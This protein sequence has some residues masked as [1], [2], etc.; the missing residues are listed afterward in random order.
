MSKG[1]TRG[2]DLRIHSRNIEIDEPTGEYVRRKF[3]RLERHMQPMSADLEISTTSSRSAND[4]VIA[5]LTISAND[6]VLRGQERGSTIR[7]AVDLVTDVLDRQIRRYKTKFSPTSVARSLARSASAEE[8]FGMTSVE[9]EEA[10]SEEAGSE[11]AMAGTVI[12]TK[13]FSMTSMHVEDAIEE[14]EMLSHSFFLFYNL[15]SQEYNV[16]YRRHDG[17][18]GLL[19]PD[20]IA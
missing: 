5:Q 20:L 2:P 6:G 3:A 12:R 1:K 9:S 14:M 10:D 11:E 17:D 13:R 8:V 19:Q 18:Y 16:V 15:D 7:E 4:R